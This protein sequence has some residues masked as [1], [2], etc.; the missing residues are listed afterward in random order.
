LPHVFF[1]VAQSADDAQPHGRRHD[2]KHLGGLFKDRIGFG[3]GRACA[4][5]GVC[6]HG[7]LLDLD[8]DR[9]LK[10]GRFAFWR[11][12]RPFQTNHLLFAYAQMKI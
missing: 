8:P 9:V 7:F 12:L 6:D 4:G 5:G 3:Q 10:C 11:G 1:T 2:T